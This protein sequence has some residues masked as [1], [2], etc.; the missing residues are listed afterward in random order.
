VTQNSLYRLEGNT[1]F[2]KVLNYFRVMHYA[3]KRGNFLV[4]EW[5]SENSKSGSDR[6]KF[7]IRSRKRLYRLEHGRNPWRVSRVDRDLES[8]QETWARRRE[9]YKAAR[10]R[11]RKS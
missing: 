7:Y 11:W 1:M 5:I 9:E 2:K 6:E 3:E 10:A 4:R 8:S